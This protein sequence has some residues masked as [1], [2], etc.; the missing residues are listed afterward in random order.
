[1]PFIKP[2]TKN[3][4]VVF[5]TSCRHINKQSDINSD[6][7]NTSNNLLLFR[8]IHHIFPAQKSHCFV[9]QFIFLCSQW[10]QLKER[11]SVYLFSLVE[12]RFLSHSAHCNNISLLH[13]RFSI[14]IA[15][16]SYILTGSS[17]TVSIC[18][19]ECLYL[20]RIKGALVCLLELKC[21]LCVSIIITLSHAPPV[22]CFTGPGGRGSGW[23]CQVRSQDAGRRTH[24]YR[25]GYGSWLL[26]AT[27]GASLSC[28]RKLLTSRLPPTS[29]AAQ[30]ISPIWSSLPPPAQRRSR[31]GSFR[32]VHSCIV[33]I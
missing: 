25:Y 8:M 24:M 11:Y 26:T 6:R 33:Y 29:T 4:N 21:T 32:R 9:N 1:M 10:R 13:C 7:F 3:I 27:A 28:R 16:T 23:G 2:P 30:P 18:D 22:L 19:N 20:F 14:S 12:H 31:C 15:N 17:N 5:L